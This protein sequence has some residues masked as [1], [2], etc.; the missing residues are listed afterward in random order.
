MGYNGP[1]TPI[2]PPVSLP[3]PAPIRPLFAV[4]PAVTIRYP[5]QRNPETPPILLLRFVQLADTSRVSAP[6]VAAKR[7]VEL[8]PGGGN[9]VD[10]LLG[11]EG[12]GGAGQGEGE[13]SGGLHGWSLGVTFEPMG[14]ISHEREQ[15]ACK[16]GIK[17]RELFRCR[18]N[19]FL[20]SD[21]VRS[22]LAAAFQRPA[23]GRELE[24]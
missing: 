12:G 5:T 19:V 17:E 23:V 13:G 21:R 10:R 3:L 18:H 22:I 7:P 14:S 16:N 8:V 15:H 11:A 6:N 4:F 2:L 20:L 1:T 9:L 24:S